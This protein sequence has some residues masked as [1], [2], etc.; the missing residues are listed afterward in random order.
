MDI[1]VRHATAADAATLAKLYDGLERE[2]AGLKSVWALVDAL[3]HPAEDSISALV[4]DTE[5]ST[6][7]AALDGVVVGFL[8]ARDED[9]LPQAEGARVASL[10]YLYTDPDAREIGIGEAMMDHFLDEA[11]QR[12]IE[13]FD[14]HVSPGHRLA[15]NFFE[16]SGFKARSIVMHRS[17]R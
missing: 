14:A 15:K 13:M 6:Y 4:D 5:W 1:T 16:A 3:P 10:R 8:F 12:G 7:V 9:L 11:R 17:T 2:L